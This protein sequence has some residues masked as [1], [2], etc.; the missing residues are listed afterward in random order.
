MRAFDTIAAHYGGRLDLTGGDAPEQVAGLFVTPN[1]FTVLGARPIAGRLFLPHEDAP[2]GERLL[3]LSEGL[4]RRR[5][6]ADPEISGRTVTAGGLVYT[7][8]GVLPASFAY[9][10]ADVEFWS[11]MWMT[12]PT[13]RGP[14]LINTV[15]R[16]RA[17][18]S[19]AEAQAEASALGRRIERESPREYSQLDLP[20]VPLREV[21]VGDTRPVLLVSLAAVA[22]LL[23]IATVNVASLL[24]VRAVARGREIALRLSLGASRGRL[25]RQ[26]LTESVLLALLGAGGGLA[27]AH[28][29]L[30]VLRTTAG[31]IVPRIADVHLDTRVLLFTGAIA[32]LTG[33]LF[34]LAP[35]VHSVRANLSP[36]LRDGG[37][38]ATTGPAQRRLHAALVV[39]EIALSLILL[40]GAGLLVRS[41]V[42]LQRVDIGVDAS[43][44]EI[45]SLRISPNRALLTRQPDAT[46][47]PDATVRYYTQLLERVRALPGVETAALAGALPPDRMIWSDSF[48][49]DGQSIAEAQSNPSVVI[50]E[51]TPGYFEALGVP[52]LRG[53]AFNA[54]DTATSP[55]VTVISAAMA[56]R[57][58][59][60]RDPIGQHIKLSGPGLPDNPR[61]EVVGVVGDVKY[62]GVESGDEPVYYRAFAQAANSRNY[63]VVRTTAGS[64]IVPAV[65][66]EASALDPAVI[67][68]DISTMDDAVGQSIAAP[69][70]RM[71]LIV[72]FAIV[73][74]VLAVTGIYGVMAYS[75][76]Q[77]T[78]ELGVRLALG[79][80]RAD[81]LQLVLSQA[82]RLAVVGS[83]MGLIAAMA[84]TRWMSTLLFGVEAT[85]P[86]TFAAVALGL[87]LS[88]L[89]AG[90]LPARRAMTIEPI[91]ALRQE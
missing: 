90:A 91:V 35:A 4:W 50:P 70:V 60:G 42:A 49:I 36:S 20:V 7:I 43:A 59:A 27:L 29:G 47:D 11:N 52:V 78:H 65:Q 16:L 19:L 79:A 32:L 30:G 34:G 22:V 71:L 62:T 9:P 73:A 68:T 63:L 88:V 44:R 82:A 83:G 21:L 38:G 72:L 85:D 57:Y 67:I 75:V 55:P 18:V 3:V 28:V 14:F 10:R 8:V 77:R 76:A 89:L 54:Q 66:R 53:R 45:V 5:F 64:R 46:F 13:R 74:L 48:V 40:V 26:L 23:L 1:F 81:V 39:I 6:N 15:G 56:R 84:L 24:L 61:Y 41:F 12:P 87:S 58:F 25:I 69:R 37:R 51:V 33:L 2:N 80:D 17:G 86:L 31:D